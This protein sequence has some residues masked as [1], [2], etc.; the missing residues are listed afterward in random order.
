MEGIEFRDYRGDF[1]DVAEF[2]RRV[3][4][5]AYGGKMWFPLWDAAFFRWQLGPQT[6]G[7]CP[8]AYDGTKLVGGTFSMPHSLRIGTSVLP[9]AL[10]SWLAAD[11]DHRRLALPLVEQVRQHN[12]EREIAFSIGMIS[13]DPTSVAYR[14]WTKYAQAFP[15]NCCFLFRGGFLTKVL[16]PRRLARAGVTAWERFASSA[17]GPLLPLTPYRHDRDVRP[18]R[19]GD[20][21]RCAQL[22][23]KASAGFDWALVWSPDQLANQ[24]ENPA[25]GTLV[26]ERAGRIDGMVNY[27][28]L[29]WHGREPIRMALIDLWA[30]D[31]L[32]GTQRA[33]LLGHLCNDLR[34]RNVDLVLALR[35]AMIPTAAFVV[36]LFLPAS[37][38]IYI[39]TLFTGRTVPLAPPKTWSLLLR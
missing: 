18:Y 20:L 6:G 26:F 30:D 38:H 29:W 28:C 11:P 27:H 21:E 17:F 19:A 37:A 8:V 23:E 13:G 2:I 3:W 25:S 31:H 39:T 22:V 12:E 14:F 33:R 34:E 24:L 36:N 32:T 7:F 15:Q 1:E 35:C 16:A 9:V 10:S 5:P 4:T